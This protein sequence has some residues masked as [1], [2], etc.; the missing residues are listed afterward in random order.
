MRLNY[1]KL[2]LA[3]FLA[4][5]PTSLASTTWYVNGVNGSDSNNCTSSQTACKTIG[6]AIKLASS[7]DSIKVSPATYKE[8]LSIGYSLT[9]AGSG[10]STTIID[11]GAV[12]TVVS[13]SSTGA[14]VN[15][16]NLTIRNGH[17]QSGAGIFN[18]GTLTIN[19]STVTNNH[20]TS[21]RFS[22]GGGVSNVGS[23]TVNNSTLSGNSVG[24]GLDAAGGGINNYWGTVTINNSTLS[25]NSASSLGGAS[26]GGIYNVGKLSINNSTISGNGA[27]SGGDIYNYPGYK[28]TIKNS[29]VANS[30]AGGNCDGVMTS[31]GYNVSSDGS[32]NFNG[33][34]DLNNT[35]PMLGPLQNNGGQ[36]QTQ[37]LL[38]G[39]LAIDAGNPS[40]CRDGNG[41]LLKTDQRGQP[42]PDKEDTGGCDMGA[43]ESQRD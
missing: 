26:G 32:C 35:D 15:L 38:S 17:A 41:N 10:A 1:A 13:I 12:N 7:G 28:V 39:S 37:A 34:G 30:S 9:L 6:H 33:A 5:A 42:R 11:G 27:K 21:S 2:L 19:N 31:N 24:S 22:T 20:G 29:I 8:N 14:Q 36:T 43:Y 25:G 40:G 23:L 3:T 4:A 18:N 16:S